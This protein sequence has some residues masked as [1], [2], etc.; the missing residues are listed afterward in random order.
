MKLDPNKPKAKICGA[1]QAKGARFVQ[2]GLLFNAA[3][4]CLNPPVEDVT[5]KK[6][7]PK[8]AV[9]KKVAPKKPVVVKNEFP[10]EVIGCDNVIDGECAGE[11]SFEDDD[12]I[13]FMK[14]SG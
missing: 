4:D 8:K 1:A 2:G 3:G 7:A 14:D 6:D 5:P 11:F 13:E 9:V 12:C 10:C